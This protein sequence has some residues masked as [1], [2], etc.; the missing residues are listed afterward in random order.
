M[1]TVF[2]S[3]SLTFSTAR[4][5]RFQ[6]SSPVIENSTISH[7][8]VRVYQNQGPWPT[9][10]YRPITVPSGAAA[11]IR[12]IVHDRAAFG[13]LFFPCYQRWHSLRYRLHTDP[14]ERQLKFRRALRLFSFGN[15]HSPGGASC[16]DCGLLPPLFNSIRLGYAKHWRASSIQHWNIKRRSTGLAVVRLLSRPLSGDFKAL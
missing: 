2:L 9:L 12:P 6:S 13:L 1:P 14:L 15:T 8:V 11:V 3:R 4:S 16:K 7:L 10:R 5:I